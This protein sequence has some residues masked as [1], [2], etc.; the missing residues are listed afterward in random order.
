VSDTLITLI[1]L[2]GF[3]GFLV[4]VRKEATPLIFTKLPF[5]TEKHVGAVANHAQLRELEVLIPPYAG[6]ISMTTK[7]SQLIQGGVIPNEVEGDI[8]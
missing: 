6:K 2:F 1:Y 4:F 7:N 5:S 8:P 3:F